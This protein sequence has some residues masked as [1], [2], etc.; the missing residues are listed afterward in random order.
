MVPFVLAAVAV[1]AVAAETAVG[2]AK[3]IGNASE[4]TVMIV[5]NFFLILL[6]P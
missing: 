4:A 3:A 1:G 5:A 6:P 2:T